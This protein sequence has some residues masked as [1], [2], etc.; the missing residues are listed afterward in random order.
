MTQSR[1]EA[2]PNA[3]EAYLH[4][5]AAIDAIPC[6]IKHKEVPTRFLLEEYEEVPPR[7]SLYIYGTS[8]Y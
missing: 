1:P 3:T 6:A 4:M 2:R 8:P 5:S 7:M